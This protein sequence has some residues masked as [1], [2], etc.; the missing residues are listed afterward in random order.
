MNESHIH[1]LLNHFPIIG[2]IIAAALLLAGL[3][4]GW[5]QVFNA[6][7]AVFVGITML[8][9]PVFL[10]G[11]GAEHIVEE[12][13]GTNEHYLE[14]HEDIAKPTFIVIIITGV[15]ALLTL[16]LRWR[17][18]SIAKV[19]SIITLLAALASVG[20]AV[21]TGYLGG[22]IRHPE[23]VDTTIPVLDSGHEGHEGHD[24]HEH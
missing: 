11:E 3:I 16:F 14:H 6:G 23:I 12:L 8:T 20:L 15:L 24:D 17:K 4:F 21:Y 13:P 10:S 1:L 5:K 22:K 9:V 7:L 18:A 2:S 19:L